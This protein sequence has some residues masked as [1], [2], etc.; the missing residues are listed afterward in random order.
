MPLLCGTDVTDCWRAFEVR[1]VAVCSSWTRT[2]S[3]MH[4]DFS[5]F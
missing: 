5:K 3:I 2:I 1:W 4:L